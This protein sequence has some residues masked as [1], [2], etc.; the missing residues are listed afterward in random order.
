MGRRALGIL[1]YSH[2]FCLYETTWGAGGGSAR[3]CFKPIS[4]PE[5]N[6]GWPKVTRDYALMKEQIQQYFS[7]STANH[8]IVFTIIHIFNAV[9][10]RE[11]VPSPVQK[12]CSENRRRNKAAKIY[13]WFWICSQKSFGNAFSWYWNQGVRIQFWNPLAVNY[14]TKIPQVDV[15]SCFRRMWNFWMSLAV[16]NIF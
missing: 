13:D 3:L 8:S 1:I 4:V 7:S 15:L 9:Q 12:C 16:E 5:I 14:L 11:N 2:C 6:N 10:Y